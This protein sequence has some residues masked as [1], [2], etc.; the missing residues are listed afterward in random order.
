MTD[1]IGSLQLPDGSDDAASGLTVQHATRLAVGIVV[2]QEGLLASAAVMCY[3]R[4]DEAW[5]YVVSLPNFFLTLLVW[6]ATLD[7]RCPVW[8]L[9]VSAV[10]MVA[11]LI[12]GVF[13]SRY[14]IVVVAAS[15]N[16]TYQI[17][18]S[19]V[20]ISLSLVFTKTLQTCRRCLQTQYPT[21]DKMLEA[22]RRVFLYILSTGPLLF[23]FAMDTATA[24][25]QCVAADEEYA[26][27][28]PFCDHTP[29]DRGNVNTAYSCA[30]DQILRLHI[31]SHAGL[32]IASLPL[33][34]GVD[35]HL[36]VTEALVL[37]Q[38]ALARPPAASVTVELMHHDLQRL[39]AVQEYDEALV[40]FLVGFF[41]GIVLLVTVFVSL[42][43]T[44]CARISTNDILQ[45][46]VAKAELG[47]VAC[48]TIN[49]MLVL[50]FG[51]LGR[52]ELSSSALLAGIG[53]SIV[54]VIAVQMGCLYKT[55]HDIARDKH[56]HF[57][58]RAPR[59]S[60][61]VPQALHR[62]N[63]EGGEASGSEIAPATPA[64]MDAPADWQTAFAR[65]EKV[66][67][68]QE[69]ARQASEKTLK[70]MFREQDKKHERAL[71]DQKRDY[72]QKLENLRGM[73][74]ERNSDESQHPSAP[75]S[76]VSQSML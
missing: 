45:W 30:E 13:T 60:T 51:S 12:Q 14:M 40:A 15:T 37:G 47:A 29:D 63:T 44:R 17:V 4:T 36:N 11:T 34:L 25:S 16:Y 74:E 21:G 7:R 9:R 8:P 48:T 56:A 76:L 69:R 38:E 52:K 57:S 3:L 58:A 75:S 39:L 19:L 35:T 43:L 31:P 1:I 32:G 55:C 6:S 66:M 10:T 54:A 23:I 5:G 2:L 24:R 50:V 18:W 71:E 53:M 26:A 61:V 67:E 33:F 22:S 59:A 20:G 41:Q 62:G 68:E 65:M 70:A 64:S 27:Y 42:V 73:L 28:T 46:R 49:V 72:E